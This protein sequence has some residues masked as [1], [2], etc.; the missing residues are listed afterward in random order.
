[1]HHL[2]TGQG[3]M[4]A[5]HFDTMPLCFEHH[6]GNSGLHSMGRDEFAQLH[7]ISELELLALTKTQLNILQPV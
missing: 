7:G 1:V 6:V 4:R 3:R 5:S 2:R